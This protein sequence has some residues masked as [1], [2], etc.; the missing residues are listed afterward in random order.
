[1]LKMLKTFCRKNATSSGFATEM[2]KLHTG[3]QQLRT[4]S[5]LKEGRGSKCTFPLF[6]CF[7]FIFSKLRVF[8][9]FFLSALFFCNFVFV[10]FALQY[11]KIADFNYFFLFLREFT[12]GVAFLACGFEVFDVF[13]AVLAWRVG[14]GCFF[15]PLSEGVRLP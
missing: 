1:M 6:A 9:G 4:L 5:M 13:G 3:F 2:L 11:K 8:S 15:I 14:F 12:D 7:A 10:L